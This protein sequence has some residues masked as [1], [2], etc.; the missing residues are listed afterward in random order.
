MRQRHRQRKKQAPCGEPHAGL[1]HRTPGSWPKADAQPLSHPGVLVLPFW[2]FF[3][4]ST[5]T[6]SPYLLLFIDSDENSGVNLT[7]IPLCDELYFSW[8]I[9]FIFVFLFIWIFCLLP[10]PAFLQ[11]HIN[12]YRTYKFCT[13]FVEF[14]FILKYLILVS[15]YK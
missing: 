1:N 5:L 8:Y 2:F 4:P 11:K 10:P 3:F 9:S 15:D 6:M 13:Y 14:G 12:S 7:G